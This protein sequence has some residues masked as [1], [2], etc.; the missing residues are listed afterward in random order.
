MENKLSA[1]FLALLTLL[2]SS[3]TACS[4]FDSS[5]DGS[6][7]LLFDVQDNDNLYQSIDLFDPNDNRDFRDNRDRIRTGTIRRMTFE[8]I[9]PIP[10][11][12]AANFVLGRVDIRPAGEESSPWI[13][14]VSA[15]AGVP[16][17]VSSPFI[18]DI[19]ADRQRV[20]TDL[21]FEV[22]P[23]DQDPLEVR[24]DGRADQGPVDF[25]LRVTLEIAFTASLL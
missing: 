4:L 5:F 10:S 20:F 7:E 3:Q 8:F 21:I 22:E 18:V 17:D 15:W 19:P 1:S 9:D 11:A 13:E 16:V 2:A 24:I 6:V 14:G 23:D 25:S 12:N